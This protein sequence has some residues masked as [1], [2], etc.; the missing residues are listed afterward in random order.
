VNQGLNLKECLR[1]LGLE[2]SYTKDDVTKAY[3][4]MAQKAHPDTGGDNEMFSRLTDIKDFLLDSLDGGHNKSRRNQGV[5]PFDFNWHHQ[6]PRRNQVR[7]MEGVIPL[8]FL[9]RPKPFIHTVT[10]REEVICEECQG[11]G[12]NSVRDRRAC[13]NCNGLGFTTTPSSTGH[14]HIGMMS[15]CATC[16]GQG[17]VFGDPCKKCQGS[18]QLTMFHKVQIPISPLTVPK[19]VIIHDKLLF[20][21]IPS[22]QSSDQ[23]WFR[24]GGELHHRL[25]INVFDLILRK[26]IEWV[27]LLDNSIR[28]ISLGPN[29]NDNT[30]VIKL[31]GLGLTD[32]QNRGN[33]MIHAVAVYPRLSE[34]PNSLLKTL[35]EFR[36]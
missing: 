21:P 32:G 13:S 7:I 31:S 17:F 10:V 8:E 19:D 16:R 27:D 2:P 4:K 23:E 28:S 12:S 24:R 14:M 25:K 5:N 30:M 36:Q 22:E 29:V 1:T 35:E 18:G 9:L 6:D 34:L 26:P 3:R 11:R 15:P 33:L 20:R